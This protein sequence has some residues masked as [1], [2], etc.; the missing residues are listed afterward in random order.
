MKSKVIFIIVP[1]YSNNKWL[2]AKMMQITKAFISILN[3]DNAPVEIVSTYNDINNYLDK[4]EY[5]VV[6]TAGNVI[7][8][9]DHL[10]N[11]IHS[12]PS[13]VG[14]LG[15]LLQFKEN[16]TPYFHEQFF[17]INTK[18]FTHLDFSNYNAIAPKLLRSEEDMHDGHAPLYLTLGEET[19][20][21]GK[22]G[23]KI[24]LDCLQAG[25]EVRNFDQDWRYPTLA[26]DYI[27]VKD[28]KL[29]TRGY[30]YPKLHS[31]L[32][33]ECLRTLTLDP[34]LD[35]S[36]ML[37]ITATKQ[38]LDFKVLNVW[39]YDPTPIVN[40][41]KK[42]VSTANGMLGEIIAWNSG[43]T[44]ITFYDKNP[45][46]IEFK[47]HLYANWNGIDY[48]TFAKD[49]A[50]SKGLALEPTFDIDIEKSIKPKEEVSASIF[51]DWNEWKKRVTVNFLHCDIISSI[52]ELLVYL[53]N[54][55]IIH[56]ST[57]LNI[58]PF[59]SILYDE[60]TIE[61]VRKKITNTKARWIES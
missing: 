19:E 35:E 48:D 15:H 32:F 59:T 21:I 6:S 26:N 58:F 44:S 4:A 13:T 20:L 2:D 51:L 60:D 12:I 25:Y 56:T 34:N 43:A 42:V 45:N 22:F 37:F 47:K 46:N 39:Q 29:P 38:I 53:D 52:D 57:I 17:I 54:N 10:Y 23:T 33:A 27:T 3:L 55:A 28:Y 16:E 7:I 41:S 49:W 8:E 1:S 24:I 31:D 9:R 36:Q 14:L 40:S 18:A 50:E 5:I 30:C 11:K 61:D